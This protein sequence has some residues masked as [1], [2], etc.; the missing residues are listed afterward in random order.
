MPNLQAQAVGRAAA[1]T[2]SD[3]NLLPFQTVA[4]SF[5]ATAGQTL[6]CDTPGGDVGMTLTFG[7]GEHVI[8]LQAV[9]IYATGTNVTNIMAYG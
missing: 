7:A 6:K 3:N 2:T 4:V 8:P 9:K 5:T 1:V